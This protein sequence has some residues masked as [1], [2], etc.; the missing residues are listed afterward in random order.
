M[1][2]P[3]L[4]RIS[5]HKGGVGKTTIAANLATALQ[6]M[7]KRVLVIDSDVANPSLG[8]HFGL[9]QANV[10]YFEVLQGKAQLRNAIAVH[11]PTGLHILPGTIHSRI[12]IPTKQEVRRLANQLKRQKYEYI[13]VDTPPGLF[14]EEVTKVYDEALIVATPE[15][16]AVSSSIKLANTYERNKL[17]HSLIV[18]KV[19][20]KRYELSIEEIEDAYGDKALAALPDDETVPM[21]IAAHIPAYLYKPRCQFSKAVKELAR[22]YAAR[23]GE[24]GEEEQKRGFWARLFGFK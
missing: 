24:L 11:A 2:R 6:L 22:R 7:G 23:T 19:S 16:S 15:M 13:I 18:N 10:G 12:S 20:G 4:I 5:S 3:Y 17:K 9:D 21:S 8:F 1:D 14:Q